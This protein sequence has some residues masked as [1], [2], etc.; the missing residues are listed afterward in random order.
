MNENVVCF[1]LCAICAVA[2]AVLF[3]HAAGVHFSHHE[4]GSR[5]LLFAFGMSI[6][7]GAFTLGSLRCRTKPKDEVPP[8][9]DSERKYCKTDY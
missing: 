1:G 2:A 5:E 6:A 3:G 8:V 9:V 7:S 4:D